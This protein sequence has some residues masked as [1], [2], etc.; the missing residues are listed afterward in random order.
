M[1]QVLL[2]AFGPY[3]DWSENAS[4]LA[5]IELTRDLPEQPTVVTRRYPVDFVEARRQLA[6]DL[7][8]RYD[9]ALHLGQA[10]GAGRICLERFGLNVGGTRDQ[11]PDEFRPLVDD[12]P[13]AYCSQLPLDQWAQRLRDEGIPAQVS[14]HAGTYLCNATLY[15]SHYL[16]ELMSLP[17]RSAFLHLPLAPAQVVDRRADLPSL[18]SETVARALRLMLQSIEAEC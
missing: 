16:C 18:P 2:T 17:T 10:P 8:Q 1:T 4:W 9:V 15:W 11:L 13:P 3:D 14:Y 12:G 6:D 7:E 5:L